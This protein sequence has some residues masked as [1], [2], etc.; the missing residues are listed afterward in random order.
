MNHRA[1]QAHF[2]AG[3]AAVDADPCFTIRTAHLCYRFIYR[4]SQGNFL[5][6][7]QGDRGDNLT[8]RAISYSDGVSSW[9]QICRVFCPI[10]TGLVPTDIDGRETVVDSQVQ[11]PIIAA[12]AGNRFFYAQLDPRPRGDADAVKPLRAT[13]CFLVK[14]KKVAAE[15]QGLTG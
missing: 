5:G 12:I 3:G 13:S 11:H 8:G 10:Q 6:L 7:N 9:P 4:T 14:H 2:V 1:I 15:A